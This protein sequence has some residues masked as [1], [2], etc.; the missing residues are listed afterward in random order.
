MDILPDKRPSR[1]LYSTPIHWVMT[2]KET[3]NASMQG[4]PS[5]TEPTLG[6]T[7]VQ[8]SFGKRIQQQLPVPLQRG[9][10]RPV[11]HSCRAM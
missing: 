11:L 8:N 2:R 6:H 4:N 9:P 5:C 7:E 10:R 3:L 1:P